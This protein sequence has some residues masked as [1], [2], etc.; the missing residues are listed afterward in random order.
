MKKVFFFNVISLSIMGMIFVG[1]KSTYSSYSNLLENNV[2][3]LSDEEGGCS[4]IW[5]C[6]IELKRGYGCYRCGVPCVWESRKNPVTTKDSNA[7]W[8]D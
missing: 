7:D 8:C 2:E 6:Y 4:D 5:R 1:T 3:A